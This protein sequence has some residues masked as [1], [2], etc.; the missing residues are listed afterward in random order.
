MKISGCVG[1]NRGTGLL[2]LTVLILGLVGLGRAADSAKK[3]ADELF[4]DGNIPTI[5]VEI[6]RTGVETLRKYRWKWG[7]SNEDRV[8]VS[9]VIKEGKSVYTNVAIRLKGAAGSFRSVD[10]N[11][12]LTLNFDKWVEGQRFHGLQKLS[13]ANSLQDPTFVADK[14]CRELYLQAGVPAPRAGHARVYLNGRDLGLHVLTEGW[15]KQFLHHHFK[16]AK[17]NLYDCTF[18]HDV[19]SNMEVNSGDD[20]G[21]HSDLLKLVEAGKEAKRKKKLDPLA[22]VL[23]VDRFV[24]FI[25]MDGLLWNWDGYALG[26]NNYRVFHDLESDKMI[27][28]P[29]GLD[30]MFWRPDGPIMPEGKGIIAGAL[31]A[32]P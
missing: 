27:F 9:G 25:V 18:A 17:G 30:Q 32:S 19:N 8:A 21:D 2:L 28:M 16:N 12:G 31:L 10:Q 15:K 7:G 5:R 4:R 1:T 26:H 6:S 22:P 24:R 14:F 20:K 13:L 29:H 23:D 3:E 11:P